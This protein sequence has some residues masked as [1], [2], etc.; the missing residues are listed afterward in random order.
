MVRGRG[1]PRI[2]PGRAFGAGLTEYEWSW[3]IEAAAVPAV[4]A[5]LDG[6]EGDDP[7]HLLAAWSTAHSGIDPGSHLQA[8]GVPIRFWSR[9]GESARQS[10]GALREAQDPV[11]ADLLQATMHMLRARIAI[12]LVGPYWW[13]AGAALPFTQL[14]VQSR[15]LLRS[16]Q[17]DERT[18][19][20]GWHPGGAS[21]RG[22]GPAAYADVLVGEVKRVRDL[23]RGNNST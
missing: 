7:L 14:T 6:R 2:R 3:D 12:A 16:G 8:A 21:R 9:V 15:P 19:A 11:V 13:P 10:G 22:W 23:Q 1:R 5:A 18:W 20:V 4:I 17:L